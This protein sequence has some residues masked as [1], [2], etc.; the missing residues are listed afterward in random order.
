L[1]EHFQIPLESVW[2]CTVEQ[3]PRPSFTVYSRIIS[4]FPEIFTDFRGK[5]FSFLWRNSR[6]GF[7]ANEFHRRCDGHTNTL[8][9]ILDLKGNIFGE[10]TRMDWESRVW[11]RKLGDEN[12]WWKEDDSLRSF[13]FTLKN[14]H[15]F[16]ARKFALKTEKRHQA[17][18]CD[19]IGVY[20][21]M[22][23]LFSMKP[24]VTLHSLVPLTSMIQDWINTRF[25]RVQ[26]FSKSKKSTFW[27][28]PD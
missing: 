12:N 6:D 24:I 9:L 4:D 15:N 1:N 3:I 14:P 25:S 22:T 23:F 5:R 11:N 17:I 20:T 13:L 21:F 18:G 2:H 7:E 19:S 27:K 10:F 26:G 8:T 16:P 28:V